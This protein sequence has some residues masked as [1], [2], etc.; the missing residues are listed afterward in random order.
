M[1]E[2]G[3]QY[4][5]KEPPYEATVEDDSGEYRS[6]TTVGKAVIRTLTQ[7]EKEVKYSEIDGLAVFEG[8]IVLGTLEEINAE[9]GPEGVGITGGGFRWPNARVPFEVDPNLPNPQRVTDAVAHWAANTR[10]RFVPRAANDTDFVR[11]VPSTASRSPVGKRGGRQDIELTN[12]APVGTVIY[13]MGHALGLWHEQSR[14]DRNSMVT[15]NFANIPD[16]DEHN[17]AQHITDGDDIG[18]Y[19]FGSIMHYSATAFS[20]NDQPTIVPKVPLPPGVVMG[21]R[22]GLSFGDRAAI[23]ALYGGWFPD[24]FT[25]PGQHVFDNKAQKIAAV[26]RGRNNLDLFVIGFDNRVYTHFWN[27]QWNGDW[28]PLPGQHVF[29]HQ[30]QQ[31]AAVSRGPNNLDLFVIGFDNRV[32]THFW[33]GQWNG[34][35]F[36]LPGQHVFDNKAQKIAAVSRGPNNLDLFVIGFD[37]RVYTHFWNG[38]WNGDWFPLP[39]QHVF[40]HQKQQIA[41]VSRGPNNLDLFVIGFDNRVYTHFWNGQWNG[42]WFPLPGQHVFDHQAQQIAAVS[43]G[44]NNLDLFV[45]GFDNRVYTHFW[46]GQWNGDWFPLPG[47][48]VFDH[49]AQQIAAVSRGRTTS[50]CL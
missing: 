21:Q 47:Q 46:N 15:I 13:E 3:G 34:D 4:T 43:R 48:H 42:D 39:G 9:A 5:I 40:D 44:P 18:G 19:D 33:N 41:A 16:A 29:D 36:P 31:I 32:Y 12:A 38:Q 22:N 35:W 28:F 50:T 37:N 30:T 7:G 25:L 45:I 14:Q 20:S 8:D 10:V 24:W 27:G 26:S 23:H 11:F 1:K 6:G 2:R 49:Q 17:F